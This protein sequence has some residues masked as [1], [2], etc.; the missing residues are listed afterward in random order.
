MGDELYYGIA[1]GSGWRA[2]PLDTVVE[3]NFYMLKDSGVFNRDTNGNYTYMSTVTE[4]DMYNATSHALNSNDESERALAS[5]TFANKAGWYLNLTING[6][7]VL[8]SPL[9]IDYKVFF[10]TYVPA[11]SSTSACAPPTGNS[12]AYLVSM[13]NG[14]AVTDVN[15]DGEVNG[16][17]RSADLKQT[18]I[19][20]E[21]KILIEDIV[22]PVVCLGTECA[23]AVIEVDEDGNDVDCVNA[24]ECLA[25]NIY[26]RFERIQRG[27]WHSETERE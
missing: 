21:T 10:T 18:G 13:F 9:I 4:S 5:Q 24:F 27:S 1:L 7:K 15:N 2:S 14:N 3:D 11:E 8:S 25:E 19:A 26:G 22:S 16:E 12:R 6:E 23:S 17:D 20:P